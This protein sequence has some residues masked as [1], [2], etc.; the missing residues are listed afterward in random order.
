MYAQHAE[1]TL[2][3][4]DGANVEAGVRV[5]CQSVVPEEGARWESP[6]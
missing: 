1:V 6:L 5:D 4:T 3:A 2:T